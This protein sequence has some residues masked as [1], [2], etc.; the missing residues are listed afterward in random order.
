MK[1]VKIDV[2]KE[3]ISERFVKDLCDERKNG[4]NL[5]TNYKRHMKGEAGTRNLLSQVKRAIHFKTL[6]HLAKKGVS[7]EKD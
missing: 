5:E 7:K 2:L 6:G 1:S 3:V 4:P